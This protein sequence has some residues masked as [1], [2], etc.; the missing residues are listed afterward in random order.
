MSSGEHL[1]EQRPDLVGMAQV[2]RLGGVEHGQQRL[3]EAPGRALGIGLRLGLRAPA[4]V[5]EV[6]LHPLGEILVL[7]ALGDEGGDVDVELGL[8]RRQVVGTR[9]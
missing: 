9:T 3:G 5:V 6:G 2:R 4:V 1:V 7:V 8:G